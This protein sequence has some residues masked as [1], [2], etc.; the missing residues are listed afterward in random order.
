MTRVKG[1]PRAHKRHKKVIARAKGYRGSRSKLY[2]RAQE[3]VMRAG[4]HSFAGRKLRKRNMRRLWISR[5]NNALTQYDINYSTFMYELKKSNIDINRK[6]LSELAIH[7]P[8]AFEEIVKTV[9]KS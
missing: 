1:G 8:K 3:A 7:D 4:E 5:I 9:K 2:R 6:M